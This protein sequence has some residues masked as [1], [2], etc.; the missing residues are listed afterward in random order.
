MQEMETLLTR[1]KKEG[2]RMTKVRMELMQLFMEEALPLSVEDIQK[3]L[4]KKRIKANPSTLYREMDFL[5]KEN[6]LSEVVLDGPKRR[7]ESNL[8]EHHHHLY[9][10]KCHAIDE[11]EMDSELI[12]LERAILKKKKFKIESHTLE[13][14]GSCKNCQ[15][16]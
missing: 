4:Q 1:W 7:F 5:K 13:F 9:C 16:A 11:M 14:F 2:Y 10:V 6:F 3:K 15:T 8:R 12:E